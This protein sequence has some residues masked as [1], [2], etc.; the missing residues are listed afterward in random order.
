MISKIRHAQVLTQV[1]SCPSVVTLVEEKESLFPTQKKKV[2]L[3]NLEIGGKKSCSD[4]WRQ[5]SHATK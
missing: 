2:K 4:I 1:F 3:I 5:Q